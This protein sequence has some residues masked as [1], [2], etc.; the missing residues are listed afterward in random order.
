MGGGTGLPNHIPGKTTSAREVRL[1]RFL[2]TGTKTNPSGIARNEEDGLCR[3][4]SQKLENSRKLHFQSSS[5]KEANEKLEKAEGPW[6]AQERETTS[7][8]RNG[9][10]VGILSP[11]R[12]ASL[13]KRR[14]SEFLLTRKN[15]VGWGR[16]SRKKRRI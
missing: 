6:K 8:G 13:Y 15:L 14:F 16:K 7:T 9:A 2:G 3:K 1:K 4:L 11:T 12:K 5:G 10:R